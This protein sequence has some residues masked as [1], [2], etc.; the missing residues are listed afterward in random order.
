MMNWDKKK[1]LSCS[2]LIR[3]TMINIHVCFWMDTVY[4]LDRVLQL[5]FLM[6]GMI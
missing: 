6:A 4:T 1:S 3:W 2:Y 5:C